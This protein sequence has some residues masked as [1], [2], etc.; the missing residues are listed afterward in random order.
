LY[1]LHADPYRS[2][3]LTP[4]IISMPSQIFVVFKIPEWGWSKDPQEN[5]IREMFWN[6]LDGEN[7]DRWNPRLNRQCEHLLGDRVI[8]SKSP[9]LST[10]CPVETS[11]L[12]KRVWRQ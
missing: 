4:L 11:H 1:C 3:S 2:L 7:F 8:S 5:A 10:E 12:E 6:W 9:S